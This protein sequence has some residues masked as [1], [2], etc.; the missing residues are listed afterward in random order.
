MTGGGC[1]IINHYLKYFLMNYVTEYNLVNC[2]NNLLKSNYNKDK[3]EVIQLL[4]LK[5]PLYIFIL[6]LQLRGL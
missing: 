3:A 1:I 4:D 5:W 2:I 6:N